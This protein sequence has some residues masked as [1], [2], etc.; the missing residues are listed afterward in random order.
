M[1]NLTAGEAQLIAV[2]RSIARFPERG[3]INETDASIIDSYVTVLLPDLAEKTAKQIEEGLDN[4]I[5]GYAASR[6]ASANVDADQFAVASVHD[7]EHGE[8]QTG[9]DPTT[10][11][12]RH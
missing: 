10:N 12:P 7:D 9:V 8:F 4:F 11:M 6:L 2:S 5:A 3:L 1:V